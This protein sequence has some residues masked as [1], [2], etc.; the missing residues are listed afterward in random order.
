MA[1]KNQVAVPCFEVMEARLL[2]SVTFTPTSITIVGDAAGGNN[3]TIAD[4]GTSF[5]VTGGGTTTG[6]APLLANA[7]NVTIKV[8][9]Q[10]GPGNTVTFDAATLA[11][12]PLKQ[13]TMTGGSQNDSLIV[14]NGFIRNATLK[15]GNGDNLVQIGTATI[16]GKLL[17]ATGSGDDTI[18][19]GHTA[20]A[21]LSGNTSIQTGNGTNLIEINAGVYGTAGTKPTQFTI[22]G[23][24]GA[25]TVNMDTATLPGVVTMNSKFTV[26]TLN[27][28]DVVNIN[29]TDEGTGELGNVEFVNAVSINTGNGDD[30][31]SINTLADEEP[32]VVIFDRFANIFLGSGNDSL[33]MAAGTAGNNVLFQGSSRINLG[34]GDTVTGDRLNIASD[35]VAASVQFGTGV[36]GEFT[37]NDIILGKGLKDATTAAAPGSI[38][39]LA[40]SDF[41]LFAVRGTTT[42][43]NL[44]TAFAGAT[45]DPNVESV[46]FQFQFQ[47]E[48]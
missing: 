47:S 12:T 45:I 36:A 46:L 3:I 13:L 44:R 40:G 34:N 4:D 42:T 38:Q 18:M 19:L 43:T 10:N 30:T 29:A 15:A 14:D 41:D 2:M 20:S 31:M 39:I 9:T 6:T 22:K 1:K 23:G 32:T 17:I 16:T 24:N 5:T 27:G 28:N 33:N 11:G 26:N 37:D 48:I 35:G 8:K 25:D 7:S 21:T